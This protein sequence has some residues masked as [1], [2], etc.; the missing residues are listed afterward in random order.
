MSQRLA[1]I[2]GVPVLPALPP[3]LAFTQGNLYFVK[4]YSGN[5]ASHGRDPDHALKTLAKA[6]SLMTEGQNDICFL[7]SESNT[8]ALTT[9]YQTGTLTWS[10]SLCHLVGIG[11]GVNISP[12][13]RVAFQS[14]FDSAANLFTLSGHGCQIRGIQFFAGVAGTNPTGCM[15][16]TGQRNKIVGCHIAGM[17]NAANDIAGA[18]SLNVSGGAENLFEDCIIG[19]DTVTLGAAVNAVLYFSSAATCNTFKKCK[20]L[21]Y[22]NHAT[23]CQFIRAAAGSMDRSQYFEDCVFD[24]AVDSGSTALTQAATIAAG[25][26]PAGGVRL[27]GTTCVFG[28]TDWNA[29]DA[30]NVRAGLGTVTAGTYGLGVA[31]TR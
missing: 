6:H 29:T 17:G 5:D 28:A 25:G 31:V 24:N 13:A 1:L 15:L 19:Q 23:N 9:D 14:S 7:M 18:Y 16:V 8:S 27:I 21:L 11:S 22:T 12:L 3:E 26:S 2:R 20:F 4:P 30:G 10:K